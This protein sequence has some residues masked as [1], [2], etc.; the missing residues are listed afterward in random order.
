VHRTSAGVRRT[1]SEAAP[2]GGFG[3]WW[4]CP[5]NPALAGNASRWAFAFGQEF[6]CCF[7]VGWFSI[8][9]RKRFPFVGIFQAGTAK[10][11]SIIEWV[12][13]NQFGLLAIGVTFGNVSA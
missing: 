10:W 7:F 8:S 6:Y 5:P 3:V 4:L 13:R 12:W 2:R 1:F 11:F 9:A